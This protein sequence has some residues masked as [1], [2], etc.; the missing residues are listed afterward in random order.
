MWR[1]I[2]DTFKRINEEEKEVLIAVTA[3]SVAV[4]ITALIVIAT[5]YVV[6]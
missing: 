1:R 3:I 6:R 4:I 5:V 2:K